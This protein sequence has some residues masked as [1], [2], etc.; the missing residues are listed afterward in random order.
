MD[1][2]LGLAARPRLIRISFRTICRRRRRRRGTA[3]SRSR[4]RPSGETCRPLRPKRQRVALATFPSFLFFFLL[5]SFLFQYSA[6]VPVQTNYTK[7]PDW[8]V[9]RCFDNG[10]RFTK[11]TLWTK[12]TKWR[13]TKIVNGWKETVDTRSKLRRLAEIRKSLR[14]SL[15]FVFVLRTRLIENN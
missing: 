7:R 1:W 2:G 8:V 10:H 5:F 15:S 6:R 13:W 11:G 14:P 4:R 12:T 9:W 3:A